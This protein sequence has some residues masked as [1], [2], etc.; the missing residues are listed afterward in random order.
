MFSIWVLLQDSEIKKL[1]DK[2]LEDEQPINVAGDGKY[3]SPGSVFF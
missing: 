3:D 1:K 2:Q